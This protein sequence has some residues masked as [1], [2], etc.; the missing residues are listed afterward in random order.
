MDIRGSVAI[1]TGGSAGL[2]LAAVRALRER[3]A[4]VGIL[5]IAEQLSPELAKDDEILFVRTDVTDEEA[6]AAA[7]GKV[8]GRFGRV[9]ICVNCAGIFFSAPLVGPQGVHSLAAFRKVVDI[10]L[11]GTFAVL[12]QAAE[13][14]VAND[15]AG[16]DRECGVI[17][18][19]SSIRA[20]DGG[21]GGMAYAASKGGVA[22]LTLSLARELAPSRIRVI[23]IAPG[24]MYTDLLRNLPEEAKA[25]HLEKVQFPKRFG[26]PA[27][28]AD[29]VC[30]VVEN[31]YINGETIRIDAA[32][33]V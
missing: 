5:D 28:F 2:G 11:N 18:N 17:V 27:E 7:V 12:A 20:F 13:R 19:V 29:L 10:N 22:S 15:A 1:V 9:D 23:S 21:A 14:M 33:R 16:D 32:L 3:G 24:L 30:Y 26:D 4:R 6:V 8:A 31:R 25:S